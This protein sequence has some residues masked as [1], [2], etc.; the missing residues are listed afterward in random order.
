M[1]GLG[2]VMQP[3]DPR[4][5]RE[6]GGVGLPG[7]GG[8]KEGSL[9]DVIIKGVQQKVTQ[10]Q[11]ALKK[12]SQRLPG[13]VKGPKPGSPGEAIQTAITKTVVE[14]AGKLGTAFE[15]WA[16]SQSAEL[17]QLGTHV[18]GEAL[19]IRAMGDMP[20][21]IATM[22]GAQ[23]ARMGA[24]FMSAVTFPLRPKQWGRAAAG[25]GELITASPADRYKML[26]AGLTGGRAH[27]TIAILGGQVLGGYALSTAASKVQARLNRPQYT[28][29]VVTDRLGR[30][31]SFK[32]GKGW[33]GV[34]QTTGPY[35]SDLVPEYIKLKGEWFQTGEGLSLVDDLIPGSRLTEVY[36]LVDPKPSAAAPRGLGSMPG[37]TRLRTVTTLKSYGGTPVDFGA[38]AQAT[39][40]LASL[41]SRAPTLQDP[42]RA[43]RQDWGLYQDTLLRDLGSQKPGKGQLLEEA[44]VHG[45]LERVIRLKDPTMPGFT[46]APTITVP[47]HVLK[48]KE[49]YLPGYTQKRVPV[50][51]SRTRQSPVPEELLQPAQEPGRPAMPFLYGG[52][53]VSTPGAPRLRRMRELPPMGL[54]PGARRPLRIGRAR[55]IWDVSPE[56]ILTLG[57]G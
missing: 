47:I 23:I 2:R 16:A 50:T 34:R 43:Q 6:Q 36:K 21:A 56:D 44:Q 11:K 51:I 45:P 12:G 55:K 20:L 28:T 1:E 22:S 32:P 18:E 26:T 7:P 40:L 31:Y 17:I 9:G 48:F 24:G 53:R 5:Y 57:R 19:K 52:P 3:V 33:Q 29:R 15:S 39:A 49:G 38:A 14:P 25:L 54:P 27:E 41:R 37:S 4:R 30:P 13:P 8:P 10:V 35:P 46:L 42:M